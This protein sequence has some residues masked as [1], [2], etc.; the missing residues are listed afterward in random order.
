MPTKMKKIVCIG[1]DDSET[2]LTFN[3]ILEERF[4]KNLNFTNFWH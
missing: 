4:T 2:F 3:K 1:S